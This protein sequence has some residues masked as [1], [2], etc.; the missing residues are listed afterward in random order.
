MT[1]AGRGGRQF[2]VVAAG[3]GGFLRALSPALSD[4]L[5]AYALPE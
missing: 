4:T 1:Y 5:V 2:V 3:G